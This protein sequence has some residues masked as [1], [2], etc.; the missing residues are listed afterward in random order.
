MGEAPAIL[1]QQH[2]PHLRVVWIVQLGSQNG[3]YAPLLGRLVERNGSV[4]AVSVC[5]GQGLH[6]QL[7]GAPQQIRD[8]GC[9]G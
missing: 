8:G 3:L 5:Q 7:L 1:G 2:G 4:Q 9:P 6:A